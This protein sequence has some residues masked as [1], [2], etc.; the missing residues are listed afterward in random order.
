MIGTIFGKLDE[1][2]LAAM[3]GGWDALPAA[4][5][6]ETLAALRHLTVARL[7][8]RVACGFRALLGA[9]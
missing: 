1:A 6:G 7:R 9:G 5:G 4:L 8:V 3:R 2:E